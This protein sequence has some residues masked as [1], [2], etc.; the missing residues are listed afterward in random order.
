[1]ASESPRATTAEAVGSGGKARA[2]SLR[3]LIRQA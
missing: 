2:Q 1:M 3:C